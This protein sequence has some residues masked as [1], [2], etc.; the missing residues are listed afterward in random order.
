M[1]GSAIET[2][3]PQYPPLRSL[4]CSFSRPLWSEGRGCGGGAPTVGSCRGRRV[5]W[6][7]ALVGW[8]GLSV[9]RAR[10]SHA[11]PGGRR[12]RV[13]PDDALR[14]G[15]AQRITSGALRRAKRAAPRGGVLWS[16]GRRR[17]HTVSRPRHRDRPGQWVPSPTCGRHEPRSDGA[18]AV[19]RSSR[20]SVRNC[21]A[22]ARSR[23]ASTFASVY[24]RVHGGTRRY[25]EV[26]GA[27][28]TPVRRGPAGRG[29]RRPGRACCWSRARLPGRPGPPGSPGTSSS[30]SWDPRCRQASVW[31]DRPRASGSPGNW[32]RSTGLRCWSPAR[33]A[34][35]AAG[36]SPA[37]SR[38]RPA[39]ATPSRP[40]RTWPARSAGAPRP[41]RTSRS[42]YAASGRPGC[43]CDRGTPPGVTTS[44]PATRWLGDRRPRSGRSGT[45]GGAPRR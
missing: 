12:R 7:G 5:R 4:D 26:H 27:T 25:T 16:T 45:A 14:P 44:S 9:V 28:P 3:C 41:R 43:W 10:R 18:R 15:L 40:G 23:T 39:A 6:W 38:P 11:A 21:R 22:C 8:C 19:S 17:D 42:S 32:R 29:W 31:N 2:L 34:W 30:R 35:A 33:W 20:L 24:L 37:R 1:E 36:S 13:G